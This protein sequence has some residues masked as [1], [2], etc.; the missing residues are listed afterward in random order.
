MSV[1]KNGAAVS[2]RGFLK[3]VAAAGGAAAAS[4]VVTEAAN[5]GI[6]KDPV[7]K[8]AQQD[9]KGYHVTPHILEYY[10]KARF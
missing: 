8:K 2:R 10:E 3:G 9:A 1:K 7:A 5:A 6:T 4:A